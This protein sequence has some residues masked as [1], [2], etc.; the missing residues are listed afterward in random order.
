MYPVAGGRPLATSALVLATDPPTSAEVGGPTA[1]ARGVVLA[2]TPEEADAV[3][4]GHGGLDG[5][6]T[7]GIVAVGTV[8]LT[9]PVARGGSWPNALC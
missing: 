2:L 8:T 4:G 3:V 6:V 1:P 7:V 5:P 9:P